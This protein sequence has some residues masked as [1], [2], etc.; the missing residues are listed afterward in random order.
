MIRVTWQRAIL[1]GALLTVVSGPLFANSAKP[2]VPAKP[3]TV[4]KPST[5]AKPSTSSKPTASKPGNASKPNA[6]KAVVVT[7]PSHK[8]VSRAPTHRSYHYKSLPKNAAFA[9]IAGISYAVIDN[10]YYKRSSDTYVYVE[11]PPVTVVE[12]TTVI[13]APATSSTSSYGSIVD[14]LPDQVTTVTVNGATF[15]VDG[16]DWYAPISGTNQ[17]VTIEPQF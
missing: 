2:V 16:S 7:K 15:Y 10:A 14:F 17:F 13:E 11:Q 3:A 8:P 5:A 6:R 1:T 12:Q 4:T 9:V